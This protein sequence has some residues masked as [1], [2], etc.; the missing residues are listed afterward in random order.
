[1]QSIKVM[2]GRR[3]CVTKVASV[4]ERSA[5]G[6]LMKKDLRELRAKQGA[7][8]G[9]RKHCRAKISCPHRKKEVNDR[10][11]RAFASCE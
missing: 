1:M 2:L 10:E 7:A 3:I 9:E 11:L 8:V 5:V 4:L 6:E